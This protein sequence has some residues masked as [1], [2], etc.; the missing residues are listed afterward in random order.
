MEFLRVSILFFFFISAAPFLNAET[1]RQAFTEVELISESPAARPGQTFY[2][3]VRFKMDPDWHIYWINPGDSGMAPKIEWRLPEGWTAGP[4]LWPSPEK[5]EQPPLASYGYSQEVLLMSALQ[6]PE[7]QTP[8]KQTLK[9]SVRWLACKVDCIPGR[10]E[11]SLPF[12]VPENAETAAHRLKL[13][14]EARARL[15]LPPDAADRRLEA[16]T[17]HETLTLFFSPK[18]GEKFPSVYFFPENNGLILHAAPQILKKGKSGWE[19]KIPLS[20]NRPHSLERLRGVLFSAGGWRGPG[21]EQ[22]LSVD[23]PLRLKA[24]EGMTVLTAV[25]FAFLGGLILNL[26]PCV[27]PVLSLK[28]LN[29]IQ[30]AAENPRALFKH[31]LAFT[32]GVVL[33]FWFLAG[34]LTAFQAAGKFAGWGFQ[35]QS[36][37]FLL[38][39]VFIFLFF[40]LNLF[41][42]FEIGTSLTGIRGS[43]ARKSGLTG[44]FSSGIF[45][46]IVATPCTAPF[47]GTALG[48]SLSQPPAI[49]FLIFTALGLGMAAPYLL[50]CS[51]P[52]LLRFVPKPGPWMVTLKQILGLPLLGTCAWL[53]WVLGLQRGPAI[54]PF[55]LTGLVCAS[56]SAWI[57]GKWGTPFSETKPRR[58]ASAAALFLLVM[59]LILS[60]SGLSQTS[61]AEKKTGREKGGPQIA[62]EPYSD[63]R[64]QTLLRESRPVFIDFT[65]AWCLTCQVNERVALDIPKVVKVFRQSNIAALKA[66][67]TSQDPEITRALLRYGRSSIPLYVFYKAGSASP[68]VLPE[69]LTPGIVLSHLEGSKKENERTRQSAL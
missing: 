22:G 4:V 31:G 20:A 57:A 38:V 8:G 14:S 45:T 52:R 28:I 26:M 55:V 21:S 16:E 46:T 25:F 54:F 69:L 34:L 11:L 58:M 18:P 64:L 39:L 63:Q 40:T 3:A 42:V 61:P 30:E 6:A 7:I 48:F 10:A 62:W 60:F 41:G 53:L 35:L 44:S 9:A 68:A 49:S 36:S 24:S 19:L 66:D 29:F 51:S 67:W 65:A 43:G 15:P 1:V 17:Q 59:G 12:P 37:S 2:A 33:S 56:L 32:A 23:I 5:I 47:M 50:L 27:L 13:F